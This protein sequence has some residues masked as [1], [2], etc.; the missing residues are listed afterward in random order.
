MLFDILASISILMVITVLRKLVAVFPSLLACTLRWKESVNLES[1]IKFSHDRDI[2]A[3]VMTVPFCLAAEK[4]RL[5]D[6]SFLAD[7]NENM[8]IGITSGVFFTYFL[9]RSLVSSIVQAFT[10][11]KKA[12]LTA[13]RSAYSFFIIL[14]LIL[15]AMGGILSFLH[16]DNGIIR[17]AMLWVSAFIYIIFL[18]RKFQIFNSGFSILTSFLYLCALE[19]IPTGLLIASALIF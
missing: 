4:F 2:I 16:V 17:N 3:I 13:V 14:S 9:V 5:Y 8:R 7:M 1:S 10:Q 12:Y 15:I 6:P 19:I 18:L 11:K